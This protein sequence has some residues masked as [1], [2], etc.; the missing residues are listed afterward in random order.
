MTQTLE[1]IIIA[2]LKKKQQES[3]VFVKEST[4]CFQEL[5]VVGALKS[6]VQGLRQVDHGEF[7]DMHITR[8]IPLLK[9][10]ID[11]YFYLVEL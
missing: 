8:V 9:R 6:P 10:N 2:E 1:E 3:M 7:K 4:K 5:S 11:S